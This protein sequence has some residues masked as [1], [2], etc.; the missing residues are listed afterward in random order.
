MCKRIFH[1]LKQV[2]INPGSPDIRRTGNRLAHIN[3][4]LLIG[5]PDSDNVFMNTVPEI[6]GNGQRFHQLR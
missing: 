2:R 6:P 5:P 4:A 1:I 3:Q